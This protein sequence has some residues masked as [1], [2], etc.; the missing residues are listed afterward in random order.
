MKLLF[1][2]ATAS[3]EI[4]ELLGF[5]DADISFENLKPD[6]ITATNEVIDIIGQKVYDYVEAKYP[7]PEDEEDPDY[8]LIQ[9]IKYPIAA[10]AY[11]LFAPNNDLSHTND[12]RK[13]RNE[14]HEKM[15]FEWM[16]DRDN[17]AQ[18]KRYYRALDDLIKLLDSSKVETE[19]SA[20]IYTI[21]T[22]SDE[23]KLGKSPFIRNTKEFDQFVVIESRYLFSKLAP[24]IDECETDEILP[25]IGL[26]K[27]NELKTKFKNS[28]AITDVKDLQL[29]RAIQKACANYAMAW[30]IPRFSVNLF[31]D[32]VAQNFNSERQTSKASIPALKMEPEF[33]M[34]SYNY[35]FKKAMVKI[36]SLVKVMPTDLSTL[37]TQPNITDVC[38]GFST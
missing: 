15:A 27:Y 36:E 1:T 12:G 30:A 26:S 4:K 10:K 21:W 13:M 25:V 35:S 14:E 7:L 38:G 23:C 3:D 9:A 2:S 11:T 16:I 18:E 34:Q 22:S 37:P 6:L 8:L 33:A 19:T 5:L 29:I 28:T 31:P 24:G 32:S 20:T 17:A